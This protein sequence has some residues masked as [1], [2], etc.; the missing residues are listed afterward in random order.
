M[1][2]GRDEESKITADEDEV[3]K[4]GAEERM[5]LRVAA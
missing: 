4:K 3:K 2:A 5:L 1:K